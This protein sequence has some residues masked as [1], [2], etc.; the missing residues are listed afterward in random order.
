M[1]RGLDGWGRR[2]TTAEVAAVVRRAR[3]GWLL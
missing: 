3:G 1:L 2:A